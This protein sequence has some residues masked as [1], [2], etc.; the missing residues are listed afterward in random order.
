[1]GST[2]VT[3]K[4]LCENDDLATTLVL[5]SY[6]GFKTH[7]MNVRWGP[8]VLKVWSF[9]AALNLGGRVPKGL[10]L[11]KVKTENNDKRCVFYSSVPFLQSTPSHPKKAPFAGGSRGLPEAQRPRSSLP[12]F[13][14]GR[15][16]LP[17]LSEPESSAGGCL[18][19]PCTVFI[20][21]LFMR[22]WGNRVFRKC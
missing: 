17:V 13:D 9:S 10:G 6:L 20:A 3:A 11:L 14:A 8:E 12:S 5:D 1:M 18:Q 19:D 21:W 22:G 15:M 16:G 4:E 7:K 2:R